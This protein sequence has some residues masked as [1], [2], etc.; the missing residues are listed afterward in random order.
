MASRSGKR[1]ETVLGRGSPSDLLLNIY[2][3][4]RLVKLGGFLAHLDDNPEPAGACNVINPSSALFLARFTMVPV[5]RARASLCP[6]C[7]LVWRS[8]R[9]QVQ[10]PVQLTPHKLQLLFPSKK[11]L[12][13]TRCSISQ[14]MKK[15]CQKPLKRFL[16]L[17]CVQIRGEL[18]R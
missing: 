7:S 18:G 14:P 15:C 6:T 2:F 3:S 13:S 1:K 10:P 5:L 4:R 12:L 11:R 9:L 17:P 8:W 16:I